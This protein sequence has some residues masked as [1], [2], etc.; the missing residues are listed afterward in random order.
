MKQVSILLLLIA[1]ILT[2]TAGEKPIDRKALI[3]RNNPV[4]TSVDTLASL[5]VGNGG[6]A[7]TTDV[8]GLQTFPEHYRNG[9]PLGTQSEWGWHSFDNPEQYRIEESYQMYDFGHGHRELYATQPKTGRAKG[10]ADWYRSNPHRLHLGCIGL[11]IEGLKPSDIK[12]PHETLDMWTGKIHSSFKIKNTPYSVTTVCHPTLDL[13]GSQIKGPGAA[14][15]LRFPYPTG[16]HSDDACNWQADDKHRTQLVTQSD[17]SAVL[18]RIIDK[19]V[20]YISLQWKEPA[21]LREKRKNYWVLESEG[22][23]LTFCCEFLESGKELAKESFAAVADRS[24]AY[25]QQFWQTGGIV[26][27]SHC[28]DKRAKELERRVV[29]SQWLLAIQCAASTPPQETGLTYNSW[30]GKF[31]MEMI[32]WH[33]AWLPLWGHGQLLDRTLRWYETVEPMAREIAMR[34]GFK[35]IRW[36]KMTDRSGEEAPSKVG[37]FLIWQQPHLIYLAELLYRSEKSKAERDKMLKRYGRLIDETAIFMA[38]FATYQKEH[39]RYILQGMIPAQETLKASETYNSPFE[40]S[41][42][43]WALQ[44]AQQWRER[45]GLEREAL[46][47]DIIRKLSPLAKDSENRYLAAESNIETYSDIRLI[48]DHP[49]VLG[50]V[51]IFPMSRLVEPQVMKHTQEWIWDNWNWDHTWGWDYPM[52][53]MNATRL[54][55]P[56]NA[57]SALLMDKRTNTYLPNG[58]NYQDQRLRCYLPGNGGLL[59]AIAMMCAGWDGC[60]EKNPGFPKDGKWDVRWEGLQPL[61][62]NVQRPIAFPGAEGFGRHTT[63]GRGGKVYHVTTLEDNNLPGTL[64]WANAQQGPKTIVFDVSGTIFLKSP[65]RFTPHTTVAGQ[66]APGDG[67]CLADYPVMISSNNIIRYMRFRLGNREVANHEGDGL[68]GSRCHDI[69]IDHCSISWSID[70]CLSVYGNRDFT[71]QWC[72][73]SQSLNNAGH[74]KGAHG[75]GGNWGGSGASYHHNLIAHHTS[76]TPRLGPSPFTQTDERMDLRNNVIYNWT[77]NGC[78]GGEGMTVNIVNNYYKPGPGTPTDERGRRIAAPNIRTS[79]YTHHDSPRPNVWDRMWHVW[80]KYYVSGNVNS[81]YPEVTKDN[82]TYGIYNQISPDA[83]DGTYTPATKDTIRLAK[84]MPFEP[85]TTQTAE[86]AYRLVLAHA[87]ASLHRDALDNVIVRDVREGKATYTG[88]HCA[89][90]IINIQDDVKLG[91]SPWPELKSLP[92]P[93]D[94]DGDGMPD[95]W[96]RQH[97]LNPTNPADGNTVNSDGY[98]M[99]EHYLN[100]I[101]K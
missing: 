33:Q 7:F 99:L 87:G 44:V 46:W 17:H 51:G 48:S 55:V 28:K 96:E 37:S 8:T 11:E 88:D 24:A 49:A 81:R 26:D 91:N 97:G 95:D 21:T 53:A 31:H 90:G 79:Q 16:G 80:G 10:A 13:I 47:D 6:F 61:P 36:M 32:W 1:S 52:V 54:G 92:A 19:T 82:W 29:L 35:G 65:L 67:I 89:P 101:T 93:K 30:F 38:D 50:A 5:S 86:E 40:L 20:Y 57:V 58:H 4:V 63:G 34:Q 14:V 77:A 83:N 22:N 94:T 18:E 70:E 2:A 73:V 64:R 68:G 74:Q 43:H 76:R 25:W 3:S 72:I 39:D 75:Y 45:R 41:Y 56:E 42:W 98:T 78:Y 60:Q 12:K 100:E 71:V 62:D 9:V 85:V 27:F 23:Q 15:N 84:P 59:T 66:T 69:I